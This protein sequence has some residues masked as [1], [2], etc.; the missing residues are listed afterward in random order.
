MKYEGLRF[1]ADWQASY[2]A[3]HSVSMSHSAILFWENPK[4]SPSRPKCGAR[5]DANYVPR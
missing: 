4:L 2:T 1:R 3:T 5:A